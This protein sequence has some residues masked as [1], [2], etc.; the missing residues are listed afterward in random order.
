MKRVTKNKASASVAD[1]A[2]DIAGFAGTA[3]CIDPVILEVG[4]LTNLCECFV[5]CSAE[6]TT[7]VQAV[8]DAVTSLAR[9]AGHMVHH[10]NRDEGPTWIVVDFFDV[11]VHIFL[12]EIRHRY[13]LEYLWR[14]AKRVTVRPPKVKKTSGKN[15]GKR[16]MA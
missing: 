15:V 13:N 1:K 6:S 5:I 2:V 12:D 4:P 7:Q 10:V 9:E 14:D 3:H 16:R 11:I 8:A